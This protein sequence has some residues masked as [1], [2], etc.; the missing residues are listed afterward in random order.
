[1]FIEHLLCVSPSSSAG[2]MKVLIELK[3]KSQ[4]TIRC[5]QK[6]SQWSRLAMGAR[7]GV[8]DSCIQGWPGGLLWLPG[9][10]SVMSLVRTWV[11][12]HPCPTYAGSSHV[13]LSPWEETH[14]FPLPRRSE[15]GIQDLNSKNVV[16][17]P[18]GLVFWFSDSPLCAWASP[19]IT[20]QVAQWSLPAA[21]QAWEQCT[22]SQGSLVSFQ[23]TP[24]RELSLKCSEL[25]SPT[26]R[27]SIS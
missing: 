15:A 1:M 10:S 3:W 9:T 16:M 27:S 25:T 2:D 26:G 4:A 18:K 17:I 5:P 8:K 6:W 23:P 11:T 14:P 22:T 21:L 12:S 20:L 13:T 24:L 7:K 19:V